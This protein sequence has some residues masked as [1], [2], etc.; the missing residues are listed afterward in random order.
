MNSLCE[1][2]L[3]SCLESIWTWKKEWKTR[4]NNDM[5]DKSR[6]YWPSFSS[7]FS[8]SSTTFLHFFSKLRR[9]FS[10]FCALMSPSRTK[11]VRSYAKREEKKTKHRNRDVDVVYPTNRNAMYRGSQEHSCSSTWRRKRTNSHC[12]KRTR[13]M[14]T[15]DCYLISYTLSLSIIWYFLFPFLLLLYRYQWMNTELLFANH[16]SCLALY[17]N[18]YWRHGHSCSRL[19]KQQL[20]VVHTSV[21]LYRWFISYWVIDLSN[22]FFFAVTHFRSNRINVPYHRYCISQWL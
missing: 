8:S 6:S 13:A 16:D 7:S 10:F 3:R 18:N 14:G 1:V 9:S 5:I 12:V 19:R 22:L 21:N 15:N 20:F 4:K 17:F 2:R 11:Y